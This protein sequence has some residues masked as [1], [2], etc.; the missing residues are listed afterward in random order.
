M[1]TKRKGGA[2]RMGLKNNELM[3]QGFGRQEVVR[4]EGS[5]EAGF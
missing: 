2:E 3:E 1:L 5:R 4:A